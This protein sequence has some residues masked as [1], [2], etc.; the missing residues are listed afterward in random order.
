MRKRLGEM[1]LESGVID[2]AQLQSA[3]GHQR[4]WGGRLG[5]ALVDLKIA[6][7]AQIVETL[8]RKLGYDSIRLAAVEHGP[9][10]ELALRLVP[11]EFA[12]RNTLL[13]YAADMGTVWVAM[14]DPTNIA[15]VDEVAFRTGRKVKVSLAGDKE[16]AEAVRRLYLQEKRGVEAIALED[17][18]PEGPV[19][20]VGSFEGGNS[21]ALDEFFS[22]APAP[23]A[24]SPVPSLD[25]SG[26]PNRAA[27][28][29]PHAGAEARLA[30]AVRRLKLEDETTASRS[31]VARPPEPA[32]A[33][34]PPAPRVAD[35]TPLPRPD[36]VAPAEP[37]SGHPPA[38]EGEAPDLSPRLHALID[39]IDR[40]ARGA[41]S[42]PD[43]ARIA[44]LSAALVRLLLRKG[45]VTE[46]ELIRELLRK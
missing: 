40:A 46:A 5:Q 34:P 1:L 18:G 3:L 42:T 20:M 41:S 12:Q 45:A 7:E 28:S 33:P 37:A 10:L 31:M 24:P 15:V 11:Y 8:S 17:D 13:P 27:Q 19:E 23:P 30:E 39:A 6:T 36:P 4:R 22:R 16:I 26:A 2:S 32:R 25:P 9:S 14:A 21:Q 43:V 44:R 35:L 38:D 29:I